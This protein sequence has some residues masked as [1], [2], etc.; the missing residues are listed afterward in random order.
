M[1]RKTIIPVLAALVLPIFFAAR[2]DAR[3]VRI[4]VE[5]K[6]PVLD[7]KG[8]GDVGPYE[9]LDGTVYFEVDPKD[10]LNALIVNLDKAPR[11]PKGMYCSV[12]GALRGSS[13]PMFWRSILLL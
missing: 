9:R 2:S 12:K 7:G 13:R 5:Q 6:R 1:K 4:V 8:F 10:P 11:T 3:V